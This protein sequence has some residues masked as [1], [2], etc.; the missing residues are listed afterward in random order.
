MNIFVKDPVY[1]SLQDLK[2]STSKEGI[3]GL[4]DDE[5]KV[6]ITK[7]QIAIDN[8]IVSYGEKYV[9]TQDNIFPI[10]DELVDSL[11]PSDITYATL[12]VVE[13]LYEN[14]DTVAPTSQAI[15][16]ESAGDRSITYQDGTYIVKEIP[17]QA[18]TLLNNYKQNFFRYA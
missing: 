16:S 11:V 15:K 9:S 12:L 2:D 7:A 3:K 18:M 8:Y 6:F 4:T 14:G 5:L 17:D 1:I 13:Q 10:K